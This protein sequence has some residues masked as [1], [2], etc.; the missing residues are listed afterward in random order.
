MRGGLVPVPSCWVK[1][2]GNG[3]VGIVERW[4]VEKARTSVL[5][6]WG[7]HESEWR[8]PDE[9]VSGFKLGMEVQDSPRSR[10]RKSLGE[11]V[12]LE[13]RRL[14]GR[15]QHLVEFPESGRRV[16]LPYENLI[17]ISGVKNRFHLG[18]TGEAGN[19]ERF[20][21]RSLAYALETWNENTGSFS[22]LDIDP[23][24][25]QVHLV[26]HI[27]ASGNLNWLIAD[28][29]GLGKTIEAGMLLSAL[30]Q[31]GSFRRILIVCPAGLVRQ[32]QEE[33]RFKFGMGDF[34]IYGQD[35]HVRDSGHWKMYD[36]VI[37]SIDRLKSERHKEILMSAGNWDLVLFDEAHRLTRRQYGSKL[38]S[39][40]R[41]RLAADLRERTDSI[42]LLSATPHQ[43]FED[44]FQALLELLRPELTETIR[45][46]QWNPEILRDM[47]IRNNKA[48]AIDWEGRPLFK[49][50]STNVVEVDL[51]EEHQH[52]GRALLGYLQQGY[53]AGANQGDQ[54]RAIGFVMTTYR[55]LAA[56]SLAAI[57]A[58]L[59]RRLAKLEAGGETPSVASPS[60]A[61]D[62]EERFAG[63]WEETA[64]AAREER[65]PFF[66]G[67]AQMVA[68]LIERARK[69][70]P[71]DR[72]LEVLFES[73]VE[74]VLRRNPEERLL[75]FT[76]Y[77]AT[78]EYLR[79][80][81]ARRFGEH[82]VGLIHGSMDHDLRRQVIEGFRS[83]EGAVQFL[84]STEAGGEGINLHDRCHIMV[85][86]DLPWNPMRLVQRVGRLYRYGQKERVVVLNV[87]APQTLDA[88]I[89]FDLYVKIGKVVR[90]LSTLG[91]EFQEGLE[92]DILGILADAL[93]VEEI[94]E[95]AARST[96]Q[97]TREKLDEA[98][99][100]ARAAV[101]LQR[102]LFDHAARTTVAETRG[103]VQ[104]S[105]LHMASF[106]E[107]MF[108]Q[109]GI[110]VVQSTRGGQ[111]M[112]IRIPDPIQKELGL[113]GSRRRVTLNRTLAAEGPS[114][115]M[116]D[117]G[118]PL[119]RL[120]VTKARSYDFDGRV[121]AVGGMPG[122]ALVASMLRWQND[123]GRRMRQEFAVALVREDG[124]VE[125][126]PTVFSDW[127]LQ[128]AQDVPG[129]DREAAE[130]LW[131]LAEAS[132]DQRLG[133][134]S[135]A[136]LHPEGRQPLS[137]AWLNS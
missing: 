26:H 41:F 36:H 37:G 137:A 44:R 67:E 103:E 92:D 53:S 1:S 77:R 6:R 18:R 65:R 119:F 120:L 123:Q 15:D 50:K 128:P 47:M 9:L 21:L 31:R 80:A 73:L 8:Q 130:R 100:R 19:A 57:V 111:V 38:E 60:E 93:D 39:S 30:K 74:Q 122:R 56:S 88:K 5:V 34:L 66:L 25:H 78:Q 114:V 127:L 89:M 2:R 61:E 135:N 71:R 17:G 70:L 46:L 40:E 98:L 125:S 112:D 102:E 136:D 64:V 106:V 12:V 28:D 35:I 16:W 54:G 124:R 52:F 85:N 51:D 23:L 99:A 11:G 95:A 49:G 48:E 32:W 55:K 14:G 110:Q 131:G 97:Q 91:G 10:T 22:R 42:L 109:L 45:N 68:D 129:A 13:H 107:G 81:F 90:D 76:E 86:Y 126:N 116:L 27:L 20:R 105:P 132:L 133:A 82:R 104:L 94:L 134:V 69:L 101:E 83:A 96:E 115:E 72:K 121:A 75:V 7:P 62:E 58:A 24:P 117:F 3:K 29:V 43:G 108:R 63:E 4:Q 118:S 113:A 87:N 84:I 79:S 33:L 59:E